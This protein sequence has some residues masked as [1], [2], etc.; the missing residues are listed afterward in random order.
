MGEGVR[1]NPTKYF[2]SV[3]FSGKRMAVIETRHSFFNEY[4]T[5]TSE[6]TDYTKVEKEEDFRE[7]YLKIENF[8]QELGGAR[9]CNKSKHPPTYK[10]YIFLERTRSENMRG[11]TTPIYGVVYG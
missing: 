4:L 10:T 7:I 6:R 3:F 1:F 2:L 11:F 8:H 9:T 5:K